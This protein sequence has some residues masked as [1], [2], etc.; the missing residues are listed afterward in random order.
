MS[1]IDTILSTEGKYLL[2]EFIEILNKDMQNGYIEVVGDTHISFIYKNIHIIIL[3]LNEEL[4]LRKDLNTLNIEEELIQ[5]KIQDFI[6]NIK[7][8]LRSQKLQKILNDKC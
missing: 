6:S 5:K 2:N 3:I 8:T 4:Y 1:N 7:N